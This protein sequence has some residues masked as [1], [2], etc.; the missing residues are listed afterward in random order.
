[1]KSNF[2]TNG[3]DTKPKENSFC[4]RFNLREHE[5]CRKKPSKY[6][7]MEM[8]LQTLLRCLNG[9]FFVRVGL[10]KFFLRMEHDININYFGHF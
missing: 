5:Y 3:E 8:D 6:C 7:S 4:C 9:I 2:V 1:M 10:C